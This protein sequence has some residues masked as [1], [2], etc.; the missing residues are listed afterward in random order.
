[1][2]FPWWS[3]SKDS[4]LVRERRAEESKRESRWLTRSCEAAQTLTISVYGRNI[5][6][7]MRPPLVSETVVLQESPSFVSFF[8]MCSARP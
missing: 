8:G 6:E 3:S 1:M 7:V 2:V 4:S 5:M